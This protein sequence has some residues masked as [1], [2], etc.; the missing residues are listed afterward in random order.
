MAE[1]GEKNDP[2]E[3]GKGRLN[4][5][6][7]TL[8]F[9]FPVL[10]DRIGEQVAAQVEAIIP[11]TGLPQNPAEFE[12]PRDNLLSFA[13]IFLAG[14]SPEE[15]EEWVKMHIEIEPNGTV[16]LNND[17]NNI[18]S[19]SGPVRFPEK[20]IILG[21]LAVWPNS[22][23]IHVGLA[24]FIEGNLVLMGDSEIIFTESADFIVGGNVTYSK[25]VSSSLK[26]KLNALKVDGHIMGKLIEK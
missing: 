6:T 7:D 1:I 26:E 21:H 13:K 20:L 19:L 9:G 10:P 14:K 2:K 5:R 3:G 23:Q 16:K 18:D 8:P 11:T 17:H 4:K 25:K 22:E 12:N 24:T 15:I